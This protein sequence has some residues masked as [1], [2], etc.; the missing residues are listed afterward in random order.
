MLPKVDGNNQPEEITKFWSVDDIFTFE[1]MT[2]SKTVENMKYLSCCDC[3][4]GPIGFQD[5]NNKIC[6]VAYERVTYTDE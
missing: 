2:F 4:I 5:L 6:Y 1:N 3:E